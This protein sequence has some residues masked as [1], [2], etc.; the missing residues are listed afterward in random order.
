MRGTKIIGCHAEASDLRS[1]FHAWHKSNRPL[2][3][4]Q[5][6]SALGIRATKIESGLDCLKMI[7]EFPSERLTYSATPYD[8]IR[9][10][11]KVLNPNSRDTFYDLGA[12]YGRVLFY[13]ALIGDS[14]FRG[15]ELVPDRVEEA[16]RIKDQLAL[17]RLDF[18]L[19]NAQDLRFA[20]G[21]L[22]FLFN[23]FF[24]EVLRIVSGRL[25]RIA[26]RRR[27]R[28]ASVA[29]SSLYFARQSWLDEIESPIHCRQSWFPY[30]IRFFV[31]NL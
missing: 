29:N 30:E 6:D 16:N 19:G 14:T 15:I 31:S 5:L 28:I 27:I 17:K 13:G 9:N 11:M 2:S 7:R 26:R 20:D 24:L 23:P 22:F 4:S 3:D 18:R 25:F 12:G 8:V 21:N 1:R 10:V